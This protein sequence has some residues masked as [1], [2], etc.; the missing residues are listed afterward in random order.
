MQDEPTTA[1]ARAQFGRQ[2]AAYTTSKS[3]AEGADLQRMLELLAL[4]GSEHALDVA[5]GTGHTALALAPHCAMVLGL[6]PTVEMLREAQH[7]AAA[8][9]V[10][11]VQWVL[12]AA[13]QL[14]FVDASFD[15]VTVRRA[16]HHFQSI[17]QALDEMR[18]VLRPAGSL[19]VIDQI[20]PDDPEGAA[21]LEALER[22]R[23]PSHRRALSLQEWQDT[24]AAA[25]FTLRHV[26]VDQEQRSFAEYLDVAGTHGA[27]RAAVHALIDSASPSLRATIGW[28]TEPL[29]EGSFLKQR[30]L[31]LAIR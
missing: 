15:V 29:P 14:P 21:F 18:R 23:D 6:D 10:A 31:A 16:P 27:T 2:A 5:T 26:E 9:A 7:L 25:G 24:L 8:R 11:N 30:I 12:G 3:H 13:E 19:V 17:A 4:S 1:A 20:V 22:R 28:R